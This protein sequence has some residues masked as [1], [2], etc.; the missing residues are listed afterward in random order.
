M[1]YCPFAERARLALSAKGIKCD[2]INCHLKNKPKF[3]T[4]AHPNG[5]VP[6]LLHNGK[7]ILESEIIVE[8]VDQ[9]FP[10]QGKSL[11]PKD[12]AERA[13]ARAHITYFGQK[14]IPQFYKSQT[15]SESR[16]EETGKLLD[17]LERWVEEPLRKAGT[18]YLGGQNYNTVDVNTWPWIERIDAKVQLGLLSLPE[19]RFPNLTSYIKRMKTTPGVAEVVHSAED[20]KVFIDSFKAG[21]PKYNYNSPHPFYEGETRS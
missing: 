1:E 21:E 6:V 13:S 17:A 3:L 7:V 4:D 20:H 8:Y 16:E 10:D 19:D 18:P 14:V 2:V 5:Q 9:A 12:P 11:Y 15:Q